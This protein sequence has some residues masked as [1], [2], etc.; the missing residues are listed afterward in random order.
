M[1]TA[2]IAL[3]FCLTVA[4][5]F[6][7]SAACIALGIGETEGGSALGQLC[8]AALFGLFAWAISME[9]E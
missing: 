8:R 6:V 9:M 3:Y 5:V 7:L 4:L 2:H 1:I